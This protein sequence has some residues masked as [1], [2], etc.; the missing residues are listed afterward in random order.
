MRFFDNIAINRIYL[1]SALHGLSE[2]VG[3]IFVFIFLLKAGIAV[4]FVL[5]SMAV[6]VLM[7]LVFR[8][9]TL[10]FAIRYGLRGALIFG[11]VV[12]AMAY[13]PLGFVTGLS[14]LLFLYLMLIA[15]GDAFYW[16]CYHAISA[17]L[18]DADAR[19]AQV[20]AVQLIYSFSSI[21]GPL[22][23]GFAQAYFGSVVAFLLAGAIRLLSI[24]PLLDTPNSPVRRHVEI[25]A[26]SKWFAWWVYFFDGISAASIQLTWSLA[27]FMTLGENFQSYGIAIA[28]AALIG[29]AMALGVGR[30]FD[31]GHHKWSTAIGMMALAVFTLTAAFGY[32]QAASALIALAILAIAGPLYAS[33]YNARVY[34]LAKAS[35][36]PLRFHVAGEG[37]WDVGMALGCVLAALLIWTGIGFAWAIGLGLVGTAG[38]SMVL[39]RSYQ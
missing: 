18:G 1:H 37:G 13:V 23:G 24:I 19:G 15:L 26:K 34:N 28:G 20:S 11:V 22:L 6:L 12:G 29:A 3:G 39:Y 30:L 27:L 38:V 31:L 2:Y 14:P 5:L 17:R 21:I 32:R 10:P 9:F 35:G 8:Q 25:E 36:F 4:H 33:V 16:A 7:R